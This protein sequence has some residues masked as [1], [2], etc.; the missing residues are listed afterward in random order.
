MRTSLTGSALTVSLALTAFWAM[1]TIGRIGFAFL[2][3][4]IPDRWIYRV[5]PLLVAGAYVLVL[6]LSRGSAVLGVLAF[7]LAGLGCS[8]LLPLTVSFG[9][10][11]LVSM[12]SAAAGRLIAFYQIGY[13]IAAFGVGPLLSGG[14][15]LGSVFGGAA[16]VAVGVSVLAVAITRRRA[17]ANADPRRAP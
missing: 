15:A 2:Q 6:S 8:A 12:K 4:A 14:L 17:S 1:V 9:E 13:G 3:R 16:I 7:G 11:E 5:I 10:E